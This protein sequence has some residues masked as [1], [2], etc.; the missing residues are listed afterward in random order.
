MPVV[1]DL[2]R[3]GLV[4][5]LLGQLAKETVARLDQSTTRRLMLPAAVQS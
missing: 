2:Y 1:H 5:V 4:E 3:L